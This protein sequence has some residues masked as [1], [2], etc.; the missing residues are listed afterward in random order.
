MEME[1]LISLTI[2]HWLLML[3]KRM[4]MEM[5]LEMFQMTLITTGYGIHLTLAQI[6]FWE[7]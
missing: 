7:K 2:V 5:V 3:N 6:H 1:F 4:K